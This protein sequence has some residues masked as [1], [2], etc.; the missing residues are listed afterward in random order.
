[1]SRNG[2]GNECYY[3]WKQHFLSAD[4]FHRKGKRPQHIMLYRLA[5]LTE[6]G[7]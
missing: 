5:G 7:R 6:S 1:M 3:S 4:I 2:Y